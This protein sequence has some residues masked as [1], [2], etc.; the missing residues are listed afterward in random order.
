MPGE[1]IRT[2]GFKNGSW[3][4]WP[5]F[6]TKCWC[7]FDINIFVKRCPKWFQKDP[8]THLKLKKSLKLHAQTRPQ[9]EFACSHEIFMEN[10][11]LLRAR[12][13]RNL[14]NTIKIEGFTY[15][16]W[17][18][19]CHIFGISLAPFWLPLG[20]QCCLKSRKGSS[21]KTVKNQLRKR[22]VPSTKSV[23]KWLPTG[24]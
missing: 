18:Y 15:F 6:M 10:C 9:R 14:V 3:T 2:R 24:P 16:N 12:T 7:I 21:Q 4:A 19:F 23:P 5:I 13:P 20:F 17:K 8:Q 11:N 22:C 1:R